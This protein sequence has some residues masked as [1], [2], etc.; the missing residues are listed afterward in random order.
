MRIHLDTALGRVDVNAPIR[1]CWPPDAVCLQGGCIY[2]PE[3]T[4]QATIEAVATYAE[5]NGLGYDFA[6]GIQHNWSI[7]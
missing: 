4:A 7:H 1:M 5:R 6:Y 3:V 2:C